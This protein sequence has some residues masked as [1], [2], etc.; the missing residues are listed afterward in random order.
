M[1]QPTISNDSLTIHLITYSACGVASMGDDIYVVG[2]I[3]SHGA[4]IC[5]GEVYNYSTQEWREISP[6]L[7]RRRSLALCVLSGKLYAIGGNNGVMDLRSAEEYSPGTNRWYGQITSHHHGHLFSYSILRTHDRVINP[8][9]AIYKR[10]ALRPHVLLCYPLQRR[11][12]CS[13]SDTVTDMFT[14]LQK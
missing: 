12:L 7:E 10:Y 5:T 3:N 9:Q 8:I 14:R 13:R 11:D 1:V 2:G 6:M 4:T